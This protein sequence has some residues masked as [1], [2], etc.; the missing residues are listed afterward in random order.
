MKRKFALLLLVSLL[1]LGCSRQD[2]V[3]T[4]RNALTPL[5]IILVSADYAVPEPRVA[6]V[7]YD[8]TDAT[9][10]VA[11]I[12]LNVVPLDDEMSAVDVE[13]VWNGTAVAYTDYEFPYWVFRPQ[14]PEPGFWG[15]VATMT[16]DDGSRA[17]ANFVI[18]VQAQ[19]RAPALGDAAPRS[20]NRTLATEPDLARLSSG[21]NPVADLYEL[22]V[23][24]AIA[25]GKPTVVGFITPG[26]CQ[27]R[28]CAPTIASLETV[29]EETRAAANFI[30]VEVYEDFEALTPVPQMQ[31]WGLDTEPWIFV[32][33]ENGRIAARLSGPVAPSELREALNEVLSS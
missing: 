26:F 6:F 22:T 32:M 9:D 5:Q 18:E 29:H 4:A 28:W 31:E 12:E 15:V 19:S 25:S 16:L 20:Q 17:S 27:T 30:H 2:D 10:T 24:D 11:A 23:A 21:T 13:S 7:V 8:G 33:D 1:A 3:Q 14:V